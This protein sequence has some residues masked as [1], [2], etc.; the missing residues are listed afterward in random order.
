MTEGDFLPI[1][2]KTVQKQAFRLRL[3]ALFHMKYLPFIL[4]HLFWVETGNT[5]LAGREDSLPENLCNNCPIE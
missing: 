1:V 4:Y 5:C 2:S 3:Y